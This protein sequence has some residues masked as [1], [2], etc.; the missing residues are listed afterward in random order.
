MSNFIGWLITIT[1]IGWVSS[2]IIHIDK[3]NK[4]TNKLLNI[5]VGSI[6]ASITKLFVDVIYINDVITWHNLSLYTL[7]ILL[8][9][10]IALAI[11]VKFFH[12][13]LT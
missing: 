2:L 10:A 3:P 9:G 6:G 1:I 4:P 12:L 5:G 13:G 11:I 7:L 8:L